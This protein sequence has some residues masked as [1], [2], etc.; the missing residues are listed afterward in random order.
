MQQVKIEYIAGFFDGEG[1]VGLYKTGNSYYLRSQLTQNKSELSDKL[2]EY[3]RN[4]Y[5]G[6]IGKQNT[7]S[8]KVKYNWQLNSEKAYFFLKEI[9]P[10]L[11]LKKEQAQISIKWFEQK[12]AKTRNAKGQIEK[13]SDIINEM[14][15]SI[16]KRL[17]TLKETG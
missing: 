2:F 1:S 4:K 17:R 16:S 7:L 8:G 5:G 11:V 10:H 15:L 12:I 14:N 3:L 6:S 13:T 9:E